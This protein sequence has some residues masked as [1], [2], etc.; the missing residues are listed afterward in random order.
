MYIFLE[1]IIHMCTAGLLFRRLNDSVPRTSHQ[2]SRSHAMYCANNTS[3]NNAHYTS[4]PNSQYVPSCSIC[5]AKSAG[6]AIYCNVLSIM[7]VSKIELLLFCC[8]WMK[9]PRGYYS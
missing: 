2:T 8:T 7:N 3:L 1:F 6:S 4:E 5:L 9:S